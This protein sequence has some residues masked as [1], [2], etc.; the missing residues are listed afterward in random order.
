ME[1]FADAVGLW[2]VRLG[3]GMF[4][5]VHTKVKLVAMR[6]QFTA[7]FRAPIREDTGN[8]LLL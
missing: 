4:N 3:S 2:M 7:V 8:S 5:A 6:F 1:T